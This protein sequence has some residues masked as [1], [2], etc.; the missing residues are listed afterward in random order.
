[1]SIS[2]SHFRYT[3]DFLT[4]EDLHAKVMSIDIY[5]M[6]ESLD[7][8]VQWYDESEMEYRFFLNEKETIEALQYVHETNYA[9]HLLGK[10]YADRQ[11]YDDKRWEEEKAAKEE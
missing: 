2:L 7:I 3:I 4:E 6:P 11:I 1:M 8:L 5:Q 10:G 9:C